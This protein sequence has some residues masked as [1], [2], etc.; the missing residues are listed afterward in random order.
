MPIRDS[1]SREKIVN[2]IKSL[3]K[4]RIKI[5]HGTLM[6]SAALI[7]ILFVAFT[8]RIF[9]LR[10]EIQAGS[11]HL[12]EF[13]PYFQF[14]FTN[15]I[16][17]NGFA[18]WAWPTQWVDYQRWYPGGI[19]VAKAAYPGLP[20]TAAFLY[21]IVTALG[22]NID[23]MAFC[24]I[25]APLLGTLAVLI[26]YFLGK[27][28]G[29][30]SVGM[31]AAIF[32]ALSPTIIQRSALGW[33]DDE[34]NGLVSLLLFAFL[35][36]RAID[37]DRPINSTLKYALASG[38]FL[39][40]FIAGWGTAYYG[41]DL[42]VLFTFILILAKRYTQRL[43]LTYSVTFGI[44]LFVALNVPKLSTQYAI[45]EGILPVA[46]VFVLLCLSEVFRTLKSTKWR[47]ISVAVFLGLLIG[48]F[49]V[50]WATGHIG[51]L[52]GKFISVIDPFSRESAPL[53]ESVA[54]HRISAWGSIY[55]EFGIG[56]LFFMAGLFF[57][58][59]KLDN[60]NLF[61]LVFGLTSLYFAT[62]MVRL[63]AILAP[64]FGLLAATGIVGILRPFVTLLKEQPRIGFKK[65][66][67]LERVG[68]E[69]NGIA[70]FLIFLI[71]MT[72]VAFP[73]PKVYKQAYA[74]VTITA[75]SLSIVPS[76]PVTQWL[77]MLQYVKNLPQSSS[78]VVCS[79]WDYGY[80][81]TVLGNVTTLADN[82][83]INST[84]IQNIGFIFM[85]NE[86]QS[87]KVLKQY[88]A[89]YIL[90]FTTVGVQYDQSNGQYYTVWADG[91]GGD[92]GKWIWMARISGQ[93]YDQF[94][95][96]GLSDQQ[97]M[98]HNE[99]SFGYYNSS[100]N[101]WIWNKKGMESMVYKLMSWTKYT[102][103]GTY[104]V[105]DPD[106]DAW[107]ASNLTANDINPSPY[108]KPAY[109]AGL[110]LTKDQAMSAYGGLVPLV[111]LYEI[112]WNRYNLD[113]P[114]T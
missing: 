41:I 5:D 2:S 57:V 72:N 4:L 107:Q 43:F 111:G 46:G 99:T 52:A 48:G 94:I 69:F 61:L 24:A 13:D 68:R 47:L 66:Y 26:L 55:Y 42:M 37:E 65:K 29:G 59:R 53:I 64:A 6:T 31:L 84:Q 77:D 56:I 88:N 16:V 108:F 32:L 80:W 10:W 9:P 27:D 60:R 39:A 81:L 51:G 18:A 62:S 45:S 40:Y 112:D 44:G 82:A 11:L 102:W 17:R 109:I 49:T 87:L 54:E 110:A 93:A 19:N 20:F 101:A 14:R 92:N 7:L 34:T 21:E 104:Q 78:T 90:V 114:S 71:L 91:A 96:R 3:G 76:Q 100:Q 28:I 35:F 67:A 58:A 103:G 74:P 95:S 36:L 89:K 33:F 105:T 12:T 85:A 23:L 25:L 73:T 38:A 106:T 75:S 8:L 1:L 70:I 83:T 79:W 97:S 113:H 22:V 63:F 98:W 30:K 15:Y 50:L 86:T